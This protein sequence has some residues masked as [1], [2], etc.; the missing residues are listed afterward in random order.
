MKSFHNYYL[1]IWG[2]QQLEFFGHAFCLPL[3]EI[4]AKNTPNA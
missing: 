4:Y 2:L 1:E 3:P